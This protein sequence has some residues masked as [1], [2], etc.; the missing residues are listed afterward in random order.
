MHRQGKWITVRVK[1][2]AGGVPYP[3]QN[4]VLHA[5]YALGVYAQEHGDTVPGPLGDAGR[6]AS[7][8]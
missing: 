1:D 6:V 2:T 3:A 4:F 7:G 5:V 8:A